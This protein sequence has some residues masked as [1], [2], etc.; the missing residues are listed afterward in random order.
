MT[1]I[2]LEKY[3]QFQIQQKIIIMKVK[4][5]SLKILK[6]ILSLPRI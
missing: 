6:T 3:C 2:D 4:K 1:K 5:I